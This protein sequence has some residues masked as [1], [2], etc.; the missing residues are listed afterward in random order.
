MTTKAMVVLSGGQDST[1][2]LAWA[3]QNFDEVH[4]VT[5]DY[6]QK[7]A[8]EIDAAMEVARIF[9]VASH[10][11]VRLGPV[12]S[13]RSPLTNPSESL[14]TYPDFQ[15]MDKTIGDRV[16]LTFVPMRNQLFL[17][18][19]ANKAVC[20][21]CYDLVTGVCQAD[22]ANYPDCRQVFVNAL[23][24]ATNTSLG[25]D[26]TSGRAVKIHAP[27]MD[28]TKAQSIHLALSLPDAYAA[29]GWSHTAYS[30]EFPPVTQDHATVLRAQGFR[31]AGVPDPLIVRAAYA[32]LCKLPDEPH[33]DVAAVIPPYPTASPIQVW[34]LLQELR[35]RVLKA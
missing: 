14:E 11:I 8:R 30:G 3:K 19:A 1:T 20:L 17:T 15:T 16:E 24:S 13:G 28:M 26:V 23:A 22:N 32:G 25:L 31:E 7:H 29:L 27:L 5:I 6:G 10:E 34:S 35:L 9:G 18:I 4:A 12:L 2:C 33:Y 21:D